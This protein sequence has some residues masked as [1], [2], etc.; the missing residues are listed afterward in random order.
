M[1][2]KN[3]VKTEQT[4]ARRK[5]RSG[6]GRK[7]R[8]LAVAAT[9]CL[10]LSFLCSEGRPVVAEN[11]D[12]GELQ[13]QMEQ[14]QKNLEEQQKKISDYKNSLTEVSERIAGLEESRADAK[15]KIS[16]LDRMT[17]EVT[18]HL[19]DLRKKIEQ[20]RREEA[21]AE[22]ALASATERKEAQYEA[23]KLRIQYLYEMGDSSLLE[24][25]FGASSLSDLLGKMDMVQKVTTYDRDKLDE[26][27]RSI[28]T[29]EATAATLKEKQEQ[30]LAELAEE[31]ENAK[32][33]E[34]LY[35]AKTSEM[36]ELMLALGEEA[37]AQEKLEQD[38]DTAL[39]GEAVLEK[40]IEDAAQRIMQ[41]A[42]EEASR[43]AEEASRA[44]EE[45]K[46]AA[47]SLAEEMRQ[48]SLAESRRVEESLAAEASRKAEESRFAEESRRAEESRKAAEGGVSAWE[49]ST[50]A[51][52]G[53][54]EEGGGSDSEGGTT[55]QPTQSETETTAAPG[56]NSKYA[57]HTTI[58][59]E[60]GQPPYP[61]YAASG[62]IHFLWPV[63]SSRRVT[64]FYGP[65]P[66]QPVAGVASFHNGIDIAAAGGADI[67]AAGSGMVIYAGDGVE[68]NSSTGGNQVWILH[69]NLYVTT[70]M[71]C[72]AVLVQKG[73]M[74]SEGQVIALVGQTGLSLGN[75]LDFRIM[76]LSGGFLDPLG[77]QVM[78]H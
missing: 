60:T 28:R 3:A 44:A 21:A 61:T 56:D 1:K 26:Y 15:E 30:L 67:V 51:E 19:V 70:Y 25:F 23:M 5:H 47:E 33:L 20:N 16:E 73:D 40:Q 43:A 62:V 13:S 46:R 11:K 55:E 71:H 48:Q 74:V 57:E 24:L 49:G 31:E 38:L 59:V 36:E 6:F 64:S 29:V 14:D 2:S 53:S 65:R 18:L 9:A 69:E 35:D 75:H 77:N 7:G 17:T 12:S 52:S 76:P 10:L 58:P 66:E 37:K 39:A 34:A 27:E 4:S 50:A 72:S 63:P 68:T 22:K 54:S 32:A 42:A 41:I 45:S 78:Y 8:T